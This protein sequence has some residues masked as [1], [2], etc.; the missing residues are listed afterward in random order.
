MTKTTK[1]KI[2]FAG[3]EATVEK[4]LV[5]PISVGRGVKLALSDRGSAR[6]PYLA[7]LSIEVKGGTILV[8]TKAVKEPQDAVNEAL[9]I[10]S[11][12]TDKACELENSHHDHVA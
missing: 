3:K 12:L 11:E 1:P 5:K 10:L 4:A 2:K 8:N 7:S 9:V 6:N